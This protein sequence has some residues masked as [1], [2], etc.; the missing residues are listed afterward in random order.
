MNVYKRAD[1][2]FAAEMTTVT[3][4]QC[5]GDQLLI[6]QGDSLIY[7]PNDDIDEFAALI[8]AFSNA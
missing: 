6:Q 1:V 8:E 7:I 2:T 3:I 5:D 4:R